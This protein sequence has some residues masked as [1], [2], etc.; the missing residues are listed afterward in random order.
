[1]IGGGRNQDQWNRT[2]QKET[3]NMLTYDKEYIM[4]QQGK[5]RV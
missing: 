5:G 4:N 3:L 2:A 1:M